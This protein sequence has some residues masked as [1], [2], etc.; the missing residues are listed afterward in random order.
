MLNITGIENNQVIG[1]VNGSACG[2]IYGELHWTSLGNLRLVCHKAHLK[3]L[4]LTSEGP[5]AIGDVVYEGTIEV[6]ITDRI[7]H[8]CWAEFQT[9]ALVVASALAEHT[10]RECKIIHSARVL[11]RYSPSGAL[12][13]KVRTLDEF[14]LDLTE[15]EIAN[16]RL[17]FTSVE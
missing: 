2:V 10:Q 9:E 17:D 13:G 15:I 3:E 6:C 8:S 5:M 12:V 16:A 14:Y 7:E 11:A 1:S 4:G